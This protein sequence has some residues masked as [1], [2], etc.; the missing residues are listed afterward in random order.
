M[1]VA[2]TGVRANQRPDS[3]EPRDE[4]APSAPTKTHFDFKRAALAL[5][6][7]WLQLRIQLRQELYSRLE[8]C[9][10]RASAWEEAAGSGPQSSEAIRRAK[11]SKADLDI[12]QKEFHELNVPPPRPARPA[13][14]RRVH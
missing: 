3:A 11:H 8:A 1:S 7:L 13:G 6:L 5:W 2:G 4:G 12:L 10:R 14:L 9:R